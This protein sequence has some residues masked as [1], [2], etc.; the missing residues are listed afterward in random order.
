MSKYCKNDQVLESNKVV[1][2]N[3]L[4]ELKY[5]VVDTSCFKIEDIN[6]DVVKTN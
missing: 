4:N 1:N 2:T 3:L 5:E 6:E